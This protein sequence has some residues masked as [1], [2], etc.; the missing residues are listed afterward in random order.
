MTARLIAVG[1]WRQSMRATRNWTRHLVKESGGTKCG[2]W[3]ERT[4][5]DDGLAQGRIKTC[6]RCFRAQG[7]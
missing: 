3:P 6:A 7:R 4:L 5:P 2:L 1:W